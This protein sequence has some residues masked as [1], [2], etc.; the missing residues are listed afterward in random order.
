MTFVYPAVISPHK[1]DAGFHAW[2][3]DL[4]GCYADG[5]DLQDTLENAR[6]AAYDWLWAELEEEIEDRYFPGVTM[7]DELELK[8]GEFV[9]DIMVIIKLLPDSD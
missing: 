3:P 4:E 1:E 6:S 8:E 7:E 9:R 5:P 2:F